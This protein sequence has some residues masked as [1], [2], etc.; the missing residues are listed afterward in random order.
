MNLHNKGEFQFWVTV[1][2][3]HSEYNM[4]FY[5]L[6]EDLSQIMSIF[7][8]WCST[9]LEKD[10]NHFR[11]VIKPLWVHFWRFWDSLE[12]LLA[13]LDISFLKFILISY[14]TE[15]YNF[16]LLTPSITIVYMQMKESNSTILWK[17]GTMVETFTMLTREKIH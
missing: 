3:W 12:I 1:V 10:C 9:S 15:K 17:Q 13:Y 5:L 16:K 11:W 4:N 7:G 6:V 14:S 2:A 8:P